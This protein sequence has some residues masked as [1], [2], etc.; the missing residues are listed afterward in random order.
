[1]MSTTLRLATIVML[2]AGGLFTGGV[3]WHAW[4][5][6]WIWRRLTLPAY[7]VD[8]RRSIRKADP[9]LPILL[10]ICAAAATVFAWQ[11]TPRRA[12]RSS[13]GEAAQTSRSVAVGSDRLPEE[14]GCIPLSMAGGRVRSRCTRERRARERCASRSHVRS[15]GQPPTLR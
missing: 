2:A 3:V 1:M 10:G 13:T 7:A 8:F 4:E 6:V 11:M 15:A 14:Q 5:R 12:P 9:A